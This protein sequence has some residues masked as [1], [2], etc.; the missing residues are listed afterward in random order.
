MATKTISID[1][2]AYQRLVNARS[3][4]G[5]SFSRVI[6]RAAWPAAS[7]SGAALLAALRRNAPFS[8]ECLKTIERA[9][10]QDRP[11]RKRWK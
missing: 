6:K 3:G 2:E 9:K 10:R 4:P 7:K 1:L 8:E 11:P 5:E